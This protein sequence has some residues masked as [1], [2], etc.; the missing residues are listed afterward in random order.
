MR[1]KIFI[2]YSRKDQEWLDKLRT[3]LAPLLR[4]KTIDVWDDTRLKPGDLWRDEINKAIDGARVAILLVSRDFLASDF[5]A[6]H[7][8]PPILEASAKKGVIRLFPIIVRPCLYGESELAKY[9]AANDLKKPL[10]SLS[11]AEQEQL[12][13]DIGQKIKDAMTT[14]MPLNAQ[15]SA[16]SH[17][18]DVDDFLG[19]ATSEV[20][21]AAP[22]QYGSKG[23]LRRYLKGS[24]YLVT[25]CGEPQRSGWPSLESNKPVR[26]KDS[27]VGKRYESL[28]GTNSRLGFPLLAEDDS[29]EYKLREDCFF[30][31]RVQWFEGG[32]IY[33]LEWF[34][35]HAILPG[36][37]FAKFIEYED[38]YV[39]EQKLK[40][41]KHEMTGGI[42]G[43]PI[44]EEEEDS[45]KQ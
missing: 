22:S 28:Y 12:L 1:D 40:G 23:L 29:W 44:S 20:M 27:L 43:Y 25:E 42:L 30:K 14:A 18:P 35:A 6:N 13:A 16:S 4:N 31:G 7:E 21:H 45:N 37:I 26:V 36:P 8:L 39:E 19:Q 5:I 9:A 15:V 34:G 10:S 2:S 33:Q 24:I 17:L 32:N 11:D 3:M 41:K 38:A